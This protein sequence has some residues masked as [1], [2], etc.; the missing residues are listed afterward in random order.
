LLPPDIRSGLQLKILILAV[1]FLLIGFSV[2]LLKN[3]NEKN[4]CKFDKKVKT[5]KEGKKGEKGK[6][7]GKRE[8]NLIWG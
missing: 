8:I 5:E 7:R 4:T 3:F 1:L 6:K 2:F